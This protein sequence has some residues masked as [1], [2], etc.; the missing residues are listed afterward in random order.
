MQGCT[1]QSF[2]LVTLAF[3]ACFKSQVAPRGHHAV[4]TEAVEPKEPPD[5]PPVVQTPTVV[6]ANAT[7]FTAASD[8]YTPGYIVMQNGRLS[9]V[10]KGAAPPI[11]GASVVDATGQFAT[12]GLIDTHSHMGV[13]PQPNVT[14]HEDGNEMT[15]PVTAEVWAEHAF[16]PQ[17]PSLRR[18]VAAGG[19]TT[20]QVLPGSANLIG[21]RS[22]VAKLRPHTAARLMRFPGAPQGLKMACGEN[23]KAV[24]GGKGSAP[25]TR[26]GNIAG[27]RRA[28]QEAV[29]YR[30]TWESYRRDLER[31]RDKHDVAAEDA[32]DPP[33]APERDL[34]LETLS[35]VLAG[36][37]LVQNHCYRADEMHI[38]L[39]LAK[40]FGFKIRAFH[41]G[42]EAYKLRQRLKDE[43]VAVCTWSDWWGYKLEA[44]DGVPQNAAM[45]AD[46]GVV[47]VIHSDSESEVRHLNQEAAK[48]LASGRR[49][50]LALSDN[51]ALR[52]VTANP[53]W[54][55]GIDSQTGTL[56]PGKMAD[57]VLWDHPPLS[58]YARPTRVFID[59]L[60]QYERAAGQHL[61]D[62][63]LGQIPEDALP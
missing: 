17:D 33:V 11:E 25:M 34:G 29:E 20:I 3:T 22:F 60:L 62:F 16:W 47:T 55:L 61:S 31:W 30:R 21:G 51:E 18:A 1:W 27:T 26:M 5:P 39:D 35:H 57:V 52:W 9:A 28:F 19:I 54:V 49:V 56:E 59:G 4:L 12:P 10:G 7:V 58:V 63:E 24:Y 43:R 42:L 8:V 6:I 48:A 40:E 41:H 53:A 46:A 15:K 38:M 2:L 23:P 13:Y 45:L 36:E 50:G 32:D 44:F 37:M 14:A